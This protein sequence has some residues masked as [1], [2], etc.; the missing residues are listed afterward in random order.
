M[1]KILAAILAILLSAALLGGCS[2][3][4]N[5]EVSNPPSSEGEQN[6]PGGQKP[7]EGEQDPP[8]EQNP[9]EGE[10]DPPQASLSD[11]LK[12]N[13][14]ADGYVK[15]KISD[16]SQYEGTSAYRKVTTADELIQA[17]A[18]AKYHYENVWNE[19]TQTYTQV[20]AKNYTESNF[21]GTVHVIEIANDLDLGYKHLSQT[22]INSGLVANYDA[23]KLTSKSYIPL[24]DMYVENGISQIKVETTSNL[25]IYSKNGAKLTHCGFKLTSD[26]N[27]VFRNLEFDEIWQWED[28]SD[29]S[30]NFAA[31]DYDT[32]GWA[33]FKIAFCGYI[34]I[35]H[36]TFG[37]SYD[38]QIDYSNPVY[39]ANAATAF[40]APY[41]ADGGNG[42]HISWCNFNA[43][44]DD[45]DGY[46][47]KMM[48]KIEQD[49]QEGGNKYLYYKALRDGGA[50]F[51]D[52]L[53]GVAIP[54]KKGF[55]CGDDAN[56]DK[57]DYTYNLSLQVSFSNCKFTNLEDRL[58]KVRGGNA[59]M[60]NCI[61]DSSQYY[62]YRTTLKSLNAASKVSA[63]NSKWKCGLVSQGIVC[64]SGASVK[65]ENCIYRGIDTLL[66]N[67]DSKAT[68]EYVKGGYQL[69]NCSYQKGKND[70]AYVGSSSDKNA[71]F[72]IDSSSSS[73]LTTD[74]FKWHTE[75]G[76]QPFTVE[77]FGLDELETVLANGDYGSGVTGSYLNL[78]K[79][80]L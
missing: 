58:P 9:S 42:L 18:D 27:V 52:I 69:V 6:P 28:S 31:G 12:T 64:G 71:K 38:G 73:K 57:A 21:E 22:A 13:L 59:Y 1:K 2:P 41:G 74:L 56:Q 32:V 46:L 39:N 50:S 35:D 5:V 67:N 44:S 78:L 10:Q 45:E 60:Y 16:F 62:T 80:T 20:P 55:L 30:A 25:L 15:G 68:G 3:T 8:G 72:T 26:N 4:I 47:Y 48:Q 77:V 70:T 17:I 24:S 54:Q 23:D 33:Y 29:A 53:Y 66:K 11:E 76:S 40:R 19:Q 7:S 49:Y 75:D 34:W 43:G 37:K 14:S 65:A 51:N 36:C 63:V 61:V 79:S